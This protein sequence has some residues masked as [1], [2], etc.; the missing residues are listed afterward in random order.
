MY[1]KLFPCNKYVHF[2]FHSQ[3][4]KKKSPNLMNII[5]ILPKGFLVKFFNL[6]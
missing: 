1:Q 4:L 3:T 6:N 5:S 2:Q